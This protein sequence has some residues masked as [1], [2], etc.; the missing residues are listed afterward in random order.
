MAP[1]T[2]TDEPPAALPE[3]EHRQG[4]PG[5]RIERYP[6]RTP[7]TDKAPARDV[8]VTRCLDCGGHLIQ[9]A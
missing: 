2:R 9:S 6:E 1:A 5:Q 3:R 7:A 4:C 8:V